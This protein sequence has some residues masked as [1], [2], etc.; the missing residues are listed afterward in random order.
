MSSTPLPS[1]K[2]CTLEGHRGPVNIV[3]YAN[4]GTYCMSGGQDKDVCLWNTERGQLIR[5]YTGHG[6]HVQDIAITMD[7]AMFASCGG[8]RSVFLWDVSTG[9]TIT[10]LSG[11][12]QASSYR[13]FI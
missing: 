7:N 9:A 6:R 8:D 12:T 1:R 5:K 11:H 13:V 3:K 10:R 2:H 4:K